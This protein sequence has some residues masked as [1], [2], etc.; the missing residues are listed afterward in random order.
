MPVFRMLL[1]VTVSV[2]ALLGTTA[3]AATKPPVQG[4]ASARVVEP[5]GRAPVAIT[6]ASGV[7]LGWRLLKDDPAGVGVNVWR[8]V[9]NT[10]EKLNSSPLFLTTD[11]VDPSPVAGAVYYVTPVVAGVEG[12]ASEQVTATADAS[13]PY[14]SINLGHRIERVGHGDLD[15][16]GNMDFVFKNVEGAI[17]PMAAYW[18]ASTSTI[19]LE[20]F[21]HDGAPMWTVDL[22]WSIE[23]GIWY[24]PYLVFDFDGDGKAEVA[25]KAGEGDPRETVA[26]GRYGPGR[27][28]SGAEWVV[29]VDGVTGNVI[30]RGPWPAR[31]GLGGGTDADEI[32]A[33][34]F[35]SRN[36]LGG[37]FLDGKT[38]CLIVERG[39]YS[40]MKADAYQLRN[41]SLEK[42]WSWSTVEEADPR[43]TSRYGSQGGHT[44]KGVDLDGDGRDEVLLGSIALDDNGEALWTTGEGHPDDFFVS[45]IDPS[46]PGLEVFFVSEN[47]HEA[48]GVLLADAASGE[49]IWGSQFSTTHVGAG[50]VADI[51]A[52][53]P[54]M[55]CW[56]WEDGKAG[57]YGAINP[58]Y[59]F[60]AG[61]AFLGVSPLTIDDHFEG[62]VMPRVAWWD[63]DPLRE[64]VYTCHSA[65]STI[66]KYA[67]QGIQT[68]GTQVG[69][70]D[71]YVVS[72]A[73]IVGDWREEIITSTLAGEVRVYTTTI[74]AV[75][76]R[77][78][79]SQDPVYR[80]DL[81]HQAM[82]YA[83]R[84]SPMTSTFVPSLPVEGL[85]GG[86]PG[87]DASQPERDAGTSERDASQSELDAGSPGLDA[88]QPELDASTPGLDASQPGPD[89]APPPSGIAAQAHGCGCQT[90]SGASVPGLLLVASTLAGWVTRSR[91]KT[92]P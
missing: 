50:V 66:N 24:S 49:R 38:P 33:Y 51:D 71:G 62:G 5:A 92:A 80:N 25:F 4:W 65:G 54:G 79:L 35:Y 18:R 41:A 48:N 53:L 74:P 31:D 44:L 61:G 10:A 43:F 86:T 32:S 9:G 12:A 67:G 87:L 42:L 45:D 82:G 90:G 16:D 77:V 75:D 85:D 76:R 46:R 11:F 23:A 58:T 69:R 60:S 29:V 59:L 39:T 2:V 64:L 47:A 72:V 56:G 52:A 89:A 84:V 20:A 1:L 34:C 26:S 81:A 91:R 78:T 73:D 3:A 30:A 55:E 37:A 68:G 21:R 13:R 6:T 28:T 88:S 17:D 83:Y 27:V 70:F 36:Q 22:G 63:A 40:N 8:K 14:K 15:G 19:K 57:D 7:Y